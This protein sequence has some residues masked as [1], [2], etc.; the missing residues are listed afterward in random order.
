VTVWTPKLRPSTPG[1]INPG[2]LGLSTYFYSIMSN[3]MSF[4]DSETGYNTRESKEGNC[5]MNVLVIM[6]DEHSQQVMGSSGHPI[7][8]T[9]VL[10]RLVREGTVFSNCYTPSPLCTPARASFFTGRYAH[11]LGTWDNA[12]PYDGKVKGI[13][14]HLFEHGERFNSIGKLDLHPDGDYPGLNAVLSA[15]RKRAQTE[16]LFRDREVDIGSERRFK[17]VGIRDDRTVEDDIRD[18]AISWLRDRSNTGKPWVLYVGFQ[19]PH[20]PFWVDRSRFEYYDHLVTEIPDAAKGNFSELNEPLQALRRHFRGDAVDEETIRKLHV[21]YYAL[22][23]RLDDNVGAILDILR[24]QGMEEDTLIIYTS[25]HGEQLGFHGLWWKCCMYEESSHVPLILKGPTIPKGQVVDA[26]VN[27]IDIFPTICEARNIPALSGIPGRSLLKLARGE[28]DPTRGDFT[29]SEYHAH[30]M[31]VGMYMI[32]WK[33]WKYIYYVGY[34]AQLFNLADDPQELLDLNSQSGNM[35]EIRQA[36]SECEKRLRSV[37]DPEYV[38]RRAHD[39][40]RRLREK[41]G[42][43]RPMKIDF[44]PNPEYNIL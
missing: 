31:P 16:S 28:T 29:F 38:D 5:H 44:I 3:I 27:L 23:S 1:K 36:L 17:N 14:H 35:E 15:P 10:D 33:Q 11:E 18:L 25:D 2:V 40:Q 20:F 7:V 43:E 42:I 24:E 32:R 41:A 13:S 8:K 22:T 30:G 12:T 26:P 21:G 37:C 9:P 39:F 34:P 4:D 19:D 6:S